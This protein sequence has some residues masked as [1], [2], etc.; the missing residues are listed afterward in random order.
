MIETCGYRV[1]RFWNHS[2]LGDTHSVL[3]AIRHE[4]L[5][6]R[7]RF[8]W[9]LSPTGRGGQAGASDLDGGEVGPVEH[10]RSSLRISSRRFI[11]PKP[12]GIETRQASRI[13]ETISLCIRS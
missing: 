13:S 10:Y 6:A 1:L 4:F 11:G 12:A 3:K 2:V 7:D 5:I 9:T 8:E